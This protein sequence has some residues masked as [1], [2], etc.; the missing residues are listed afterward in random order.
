MW[1]WIF[2]AMFVVPLT[3]LVAYVLV[4][5]RHHPV[6]HPLKGDGQGWGNLWPR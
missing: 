4:R 1:M 6:D 2:V 3:M 5:E